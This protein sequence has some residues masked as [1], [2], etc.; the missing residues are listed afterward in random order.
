MAAI[1]ST[2]ERLSLR[3]PRIPINCAT[4]GESTIKYVHDCFNPAE[5]GTPVFVSYR[6]ATF[7]DILGLLRNLPPSL[8]RLGLHVGTVDIANNGPTMDI[9]LSLPLPRAPNR[10]R[11]GANKRF[12]QWFNRE[13]SLF[14]DQVRRLCHRKELGHGVRYLDHAFH[15]LPPWRVLAADGLHPSFEGVAMLAL[16][17]RRLLSSANRW[18]YHNRQPATN[19]T[20]PRFDS[21]ALA[22]YVNPMAPM[23]PRTPCPQAHSPTSTPPSPCTTA[24]QAPTAKVLCPPPPFTTS[25]GIQPAQL[26]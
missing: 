18:H 22:G 13:G 15:E 21:R 9:H 3:F 17:Y 26:L 6:G 5:P 8:P 25:E 4:I 7:G 20:P 2:T 12:V 1:Y 16:H 14:V 10:R 11:R 23:S 19:G 24:A